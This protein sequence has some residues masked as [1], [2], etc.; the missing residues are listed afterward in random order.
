MAK[1]TK[2][3]VTKKSKRKVSNIMLV[4]TCAMIILYPAGWKKL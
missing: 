3:K 1:K 2:K 4:V